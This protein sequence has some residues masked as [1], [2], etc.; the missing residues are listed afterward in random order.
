MTKTA[1]PITPSVLEWAIAESGYPPARVAESA[2]VD[3][4]T[5][6]HWLA[7][8]EQ[9]GLT[10]MRRVAA[11]LHRQL[12]VFLLPVPPAAEGTDVRFRHP[13]GSRSAR[14]LSAIERR[15]V[16]RARRLQEAQ[17][18]LLEELGWP[19]PELDGVAASESPESAAVAFRDR[20]GVSLS[21]QRATRS[22]G[23]AFDRWR[24]ALEAQGISVLQF[25]MGEETCRGFSL[26]HDR[27]P[28]IAVNTAWPDEAR[29]FTLFHEAGHLLTRTDSA[30][31]RAVLTPHASDP[32]ERWC[33][34][35]AAAVLIPAEALDGIARVADIKSLSSLA[36]SMRVSLRAMALRLIDLGKATW[37]LYTD[38]PPVSDLKPKGGGGGGRDRA[39]IRVDEFGPRSARMFIDAVRR[40]VISESQALD[41]LDIP[42][43]A[44]EQMAGEFVG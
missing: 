19:V 43:R 23:A 25:S 28:L 20:L 40:D 2:G 42:S 34:A 11:T 14:P 30:C 38:I 15:Y 35:F 3:F 6:S 5:L 24:E 8:T 29:I 33:E 13:L 36:R 32:E 37:Q 18:W 10:E 27:V 9:P 4:E 39:E 7:G 22:A 31:A 17:A 21:E 12:T 1:V 16:R 26:S 44:F 41:F